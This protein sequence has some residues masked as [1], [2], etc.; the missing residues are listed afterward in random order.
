MR[1][2]SLPLEFSSFK[3]RSAKLVHGTNSNFIG[4][5]VLVVKSFDSSTSALAG[6]QAA[7]HRVS[8]LESARAAVADA[9]SPASASGSARVTNLR[10]F[11]PPLKRLRLI[12]DMFTKLQ[13]TKHCQE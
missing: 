1:S 6:S 11:E 3:K 2:H 12:G 10:T 5:P 8:G 4:M 7:Q 9:S 13:F